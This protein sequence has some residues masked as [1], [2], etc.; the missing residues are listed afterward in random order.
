M[1]DAAA[2]QKRG[3]KRIVDTEVDENKVADNFFKK[4]RG[5][6][7]EFSQRRAK[8]KERQAKADRV[9]RARELF[10]SGMNKVRVSEELG[11]NYNTVCR[12]LKDVVGPAK[13]E[14][15][16]DVFE[17]HLIGSIDN[18]IADARIAARDEEQQNILE[19]AENQSSPADKYQA[20]IA[21]SAIKM[22]RDSLLNIRGP[23]TVRELSELDQLIR[24]NLGLNAKS[25]GGSGSLTIDISI[26]NNSKAANGGSQV[27]V[28]AE[29]V[30]Q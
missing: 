8:L 9:V 30:D 22:L 17:D 6:V 24:R 29:E 16:V 2:P 18:T 10:V 15:K 27:V 1:S 21:A 11:V 12:W 7:D 20:Y 23:R 4:D 28:E 26:L 19:V 5:R 14:E 25:G 3:R 13:G